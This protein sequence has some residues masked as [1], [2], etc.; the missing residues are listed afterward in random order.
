MIGIDVFAPNKISGPVR[1]PTQATEMLRWL[2]RGAGK[3]TAERAVRM[4]F[5]LR[6]AAE[7]VISRTRWT[8]PGT[9]STTSVLLVCVIRPRGK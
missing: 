8:A 2:L 6:P 5:E 1:L 4:V 9:Q 7:A 3:T